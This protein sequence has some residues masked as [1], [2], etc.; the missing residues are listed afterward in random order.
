MVEVLVALEVSSSEALEDVAEGAALLDHPNLAA[1]E[2]PEVV[3]EISTL[4]H[5]MVPPTPRE[6][7]AVVVL[8]GHYLVVAYQVVEAADQIHFLVAVA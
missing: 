6:V 1:V 7:V 5:P 8:Q 3:V 2:N 4:L